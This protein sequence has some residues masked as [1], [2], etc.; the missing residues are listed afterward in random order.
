MK[1]IKDKLFYLYEIVLAILSVAAVFLAF[2][3]L[4]N[5]LSKFQALID[6]TILAIF[7]TDYFVRLITA[8][9]KKQFLKTNM[10]DLIS[11]I[12]F[13]S[14]F[15]IFRIARI[16]KIFKIIK[17]AKL[18][19]VMIFF[20]RLI[21]KCNIFLNTNGFKYMLLL[22]SFT[23]II[24][25]VMIH[26]AENMTL[27]DG[28]WWALVTATTVGYGDISPTTLIGRIVA[29][30]LMVVGIGLIG[31]LTSAITNYFLIK[32]LRK[33]MRSEIIDTIKLQLDDISSLTDSD[34]DDICN[35]LKTLNK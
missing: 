11:I 2:I 13:S 3:D 17:I 7:V 6:N 18:S 30:I 20:A 14:I 19:K 16:A 8:K 26:Y 21:K 9:N 23:V 15:R 4:F 27:Q 29:V 34:I 28:F 1:N 31:S 33:S 12:P 5:G 22:S 35:I 24:G 32:P 25:G 10:L